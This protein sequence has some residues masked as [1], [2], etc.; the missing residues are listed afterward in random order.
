MFDGDGH[1]GEVTRADY[2]PSLDAPI[3]LALVDYGLEPGDLTVRV[4]GS[5]A[6]AELVDLPFV[7]G[8]S[9]SGRL[10]RYP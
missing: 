5:D 4:D 10:P 3:A 6:A 8:S 2:S 1:V 7:E 9:R